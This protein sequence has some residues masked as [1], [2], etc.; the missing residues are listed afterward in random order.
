MTTA[1][2][3][4]DTRATLPTPEQ[5]PDDLGTLKRLVVELLVTLR[6][7]RRGREVLEHRLDRLLRRLYGP[8]SERFDPSQPL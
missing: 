4:G 5:L 2:L 8:K 1:D 3:L 7:E 6:Q